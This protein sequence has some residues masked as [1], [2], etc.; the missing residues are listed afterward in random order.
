MRNILVSVSA[1]LL[2]KLRFQV[3]IAKLV[4]NLNAPNLAAIGKVTS[5]Q[6]GCGGEMFQQVYVY[7]IFGHARKSICK[8]LR[9]CVTLLRKLRKS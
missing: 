5:R 1:I 8:F 6:S 2:K 4:I 7:V 3:R 9:T